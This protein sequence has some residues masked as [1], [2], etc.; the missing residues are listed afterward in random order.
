MIIKDKA[1]YKKLAL[2][3]V[4]IILQNL[5]TY[6][7]T[8]A[9]N[10]MIGSLGDTAVSGVYMGG[11]IQTVL[12]VLT[13]GIEGA[14]LLLSAQYWGKRDTANIRKIVKLGIAFSVAAGLLFSVLCSVTPTG[15]LRIF[16]DSETVVQSGAEYVRIVCWSYL[17][18]CITQSLIAA[19]R[20]VEST[21]I[22]LIVSLIS[23]AVDV[24]LNYVMIFGKFG[25]P[26]MGIA[27]AALATLIARICETAVIAVYV[28]FIDRKLRLIRR[29][30]LNLRTLFTFDGTLLRDFIQYGTPLVAGQLV[31]GVN[32]TANSI[33]LGR[34][35]ESVIT[36]VSLANTIN[37]MVFVMTGGL[38]SAV[39]ILTGKKVGAGKIDDIRVYSNTVQFLF[40]AL[41]LISS[42]FL[43]FIRAPFIS[44]YSITDEARMYSMQLIGV[45]SLTIIG[46]CYQAPSLYGLVKSGG[47]VNFVFRNDS[48]FVFGV[49]IPS[50]ILTAALGCPPWVVFF[51]LKVDQ[52]LKCIVAFFKIRKYNWM[53]NLTR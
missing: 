28:L 21:R 1:F 2:L 9:D 38:S 8:L 44:L 46:T 52:L 40:F 45:L 29:E 32:L 26:K 14:I 13:A 48:I 51:C 27:G 25:F 35:D 22:G 43:L 30:S 5:V 24:T 31:W 19:M 33:I 42:A 39:G 37:N 34:F 6:S 3:A 16:T 49:V 47:D 41:G 12:Q 15:V 50:A 53:K 17:F 11:Q 7:V 10:L 4:P 23:L 18:F 20:S 36:A